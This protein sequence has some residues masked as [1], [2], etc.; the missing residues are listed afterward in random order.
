MQKKP[1]KIQKFFHMRKCARTLFVKKRDK[2]V[3]NAKI[4][5][6]L[7]R[8]G[9]KIVPLCR[10]WGRMP[11]NEGGGFQPTQWTKES[12]TKEDGTKE[13]GQSDCPVTEER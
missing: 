4:N 6:K 13:D 11:V 2:R 1:A 12:G 8:N 7:W 9:K 5:E 3:K 10:I